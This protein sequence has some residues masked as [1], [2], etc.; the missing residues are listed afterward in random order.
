M[1]RED[2]RFKTQEEAQAFLDGVNYVNDSSIETIGVNRSPHPDGR[3][4][5]AVFEDR[6]IKEEPEA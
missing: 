1:I 3:N 6:D 2:K 5:I 4:Y